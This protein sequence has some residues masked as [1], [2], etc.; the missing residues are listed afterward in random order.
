MTYGWGVLGTGNIA[1]SM[2][3]AFSLVPVARCAAV[4]SRSAEKAR[5]FAD[6]WGFYR[7]YGDYDALLADSAVD[8]VYIATPNAR[9]KADILA[10]LAAGKHVLCE[11]PMTLS[12][13]D[14]AVC[15]DAAERNGLILMEALWTAYFPAMQK[16]VELVRDGAIG[17]PIHLSANFVSYRDPA[18]HPILFDPALGGGARNDL[19]IYPVAAALMLAG[20]VVDSTVRL[21]QGETGVDEMTSMILEHDN[22]A[23][24]QLTCGFRAEMPIAVALT[25]T[26]G[27]LQI[28]RTFHCPQNVTLTRNGATSSHTLPSLGRGYA[29]ETIAMHDQISGGGRAGLLWGKDQTLAAAHILAG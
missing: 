16:A 11:K 4:A 1:R 27:T 12:E 3:E 28:A 10:A 26:E 29:H 5:A 7:A 2:A 8:I 18:S 6:H 23:V 13:E 21:L 17:A 22:G 9:H 24:S 25:G 14:S 15:F 19:G 20:P